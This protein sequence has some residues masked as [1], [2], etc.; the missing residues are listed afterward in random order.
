MTAKAAGSTYE[1]LI[2]VGWNDELLIQHGMMLPPGGVTP[3]FS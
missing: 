3:S 2:A 1:S